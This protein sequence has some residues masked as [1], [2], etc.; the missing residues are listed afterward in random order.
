MCIVYNHRYY[1]IYGIMNGQ[2]VYSC[3]QAL[4]NKSRDKA[5]ELCLL[6]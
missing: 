3:T 4:V 5:A 1:N 2:I 6:K